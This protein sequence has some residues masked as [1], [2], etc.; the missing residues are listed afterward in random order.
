MTE[1]KKEYKKVI[2]AG[3]IMVSVLS[4]AF[5]FREYYFINR[6]FDLI[7]VYQNRIATYRTEVNNILT[8]N[9]APLSV[10]DVDLVA[11]WMTFDY[12]NK[13]FKLPANYLKVNLNISDT[14]YPNLSLNAYTRGK[15]LDRIF[16]LANVKKAV[17]D[18]LANNK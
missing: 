17:S 18:Y 7:Q 16:F 1:N 2:V 14:R 3:L 10:E 12:I 9:H 13:L 15:K 8:K 11:P 6:R 5:A 4:W